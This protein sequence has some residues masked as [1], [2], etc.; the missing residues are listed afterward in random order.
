MPRLQLSTVVFLLL[1]RALRYDLIDRPGVL[2]NAGYNVV[3]YSQGGA[4]QHTD[5]TDSIISTADVGGKNGLRKPQ[6]ADV[7]FWII[8]KSL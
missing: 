5:G 3:L 8:H 2:G 6:Y 4:Q 1:E 7:A